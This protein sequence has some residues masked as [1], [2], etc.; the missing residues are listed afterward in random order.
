VE[1]IDFINKVVEKRYKPGFREFKINKEY[2]GI[3][4]NELK[5]LITEKFDVCPKPIFE[6]LLNSNYA[7]KFNNK[8]EEYMK[9]NNIKQKVVLGRDCNLIPGYMIGCS[10]CCFNINSL[11]YYSL[12]SLI[13]ENLIK[14]ETVEKISTSLKELYKDDEDAVK[15][16]LKML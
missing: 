1:N 13:S 5:E 14:K 6:G 4:K 8:I 2:F 10:G 11:D 15:T 12:R 16:F 3:T 9:E 7:K